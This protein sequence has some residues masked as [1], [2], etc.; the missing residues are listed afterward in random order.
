MPST[1]TFIMRLSTIHSS[2]P[3][4]HLN[5]LLLFLLC[6]LNE[7]KYMRKKNAKLYLISSNM[8]Q[9]FLSL[10]L[11]HCVFHSFLCRLTFVYHLKLF[12]SFCFFLHLIWI[13]SCSLMS[14]KF[15]R[16]NQEFIKFCVIFINFSYLLL[17]F[18]TCINLV[19]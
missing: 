17:F 13:C 10:S 3:H 8:I 1:I 15:I 9:T 14:S 12:H 4:T 5:V 11:F 7:I 18:C 19:L 16:K 2:P 6:R